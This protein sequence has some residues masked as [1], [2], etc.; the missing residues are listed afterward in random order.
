MI[1]GRIQLGIIVVLSALLLGLGWYT[2][3]L[4]AETGEYEIK[5]MQANED[6]HAAYLVAEDLEKEIKERDV[7]LA[8]VETERQVL[9][10]EFKA[11]QRRYEDALRKDPSARAWSEQPVPAAVVDLLRNSRPAN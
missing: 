9:R 7:L 2:K 11:W 8:K 1:F 4:I 3:T 6:L 10:T 5:L